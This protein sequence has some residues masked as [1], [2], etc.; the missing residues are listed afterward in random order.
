[1]HF[2]G[3]QW[4]AII[5]LDLFGRA[6]LLLIV[7]LNILIVPI[8]FVSSFWHLAILVPVYHS[9]AALRRRGWI[10]LLVTLIVT[11]ILFVTSVTA[12]WYSL[13][14]SGRSTA[15]LA[16]DCLWIEGTITS[17][18]RRIAYVLLVLVF[19]NLLPVLIVS[20]LAYRSRKKSK[21]S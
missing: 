19:L 7:T 13:E 16:G 20:G 10:G 9:M 3:S 2:S 11:N 8:S 5:A 14:K 12:V 18:V 21:S 1:M 6:A 15:C 4:L 17:G